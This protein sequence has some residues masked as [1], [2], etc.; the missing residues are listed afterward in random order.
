M[1]S[2]I[3]Q[4]NRIQYTPQIVRGGIHP[5]I[6]IRPPVNDPVKMLAT[7]CKDNKVTYLGDVHGQCF[8]PELVGRSAKELKQAGVDLLAIEFVKFSDNAAFREALAGGKNAIKDFIYNAW[9]PTHGEAWVESIASALAEVHNA[10]IAVAGIDRHMAGG[11]PKNP[12]EAISYMNRRLALNIA[13]NAA[14]ER[15]E[16]AIGAS[17]TL[18]WA[19]TGHFVN[20]FENG[21]KDMR[22]GPVVAFANT[23]GGTGCSLNDR[24]DNSH[25]LIHYRRQQRA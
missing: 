17:K 20:S 11:A 9:A 24:D 22:P 21:P 8:I 6:K 2:S 5:F 4:S 13:W 7:L 15:E 19:G 25:V 18:V 12:M 10:G 23:Q 3:G 16:R 14:A 1:F